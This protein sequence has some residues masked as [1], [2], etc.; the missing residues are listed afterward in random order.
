M[1]KNDKGAMKMSRIYTHR[2]GLF[3]DYKREVTDFQNTHF[4][5]ED[6]HIEEV[7]FAFIRFEPHFWHRETLYYD[8][9]TVDAITVLGLTIGKGYSY[10]SRP[11]ADWPAEELNFA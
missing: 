1:Y 10:D 4:N 2:R 11:V 9:H 7:W 5:N 3:F 8:G 6:W